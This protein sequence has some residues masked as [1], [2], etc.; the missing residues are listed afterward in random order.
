MM[1]SIMSSA[2][3]NIRNNTICFLFSKNTSTTVI[4]TLS[5]H[6]ALPISPRSAQSISNSHPAVSRADE[7]PAVMSPELIV[8]AGEDRAR[9]EEH[10]SE[11]QS[12]VNLVCRPLLEKKNEPPPTCR[13]GTTPR[14]CPGGTQP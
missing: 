13:S 14:Q 1:C 3:S 6:D 9:S 10:T 12:H 4:Y 2:E 5:L 11:L 7:I 8:A